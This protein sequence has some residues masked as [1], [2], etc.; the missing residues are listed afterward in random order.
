VPGGRRTA[1][2]N[3][4][5]A[6]PF[7]DERPVSGYSAPC[8]GVSSPSKALWCPQMVHKWSPC[9]RSLDQQRGHHMG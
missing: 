1:G 7:F 5:V 4:G 8:P 6:H 3:T 9:P 2:R